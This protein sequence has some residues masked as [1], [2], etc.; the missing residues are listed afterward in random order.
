MSRRKRN[1]QLLREQCLRIAALLELTQC[2]D[3]EM[4]RFLGH[5][6]GSTLGKVREGLSFLDSES[7]AKLGGFE[8]RE[9]CHPNLH[10]LLTGR[11]K[12]FLPKARTSKDEFEALCVLALSQAKRTTG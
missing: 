5:A 4:S 2:T 9:L 3:A 1:P 12:P 6:N 7:L 8:V 11:G 10:W